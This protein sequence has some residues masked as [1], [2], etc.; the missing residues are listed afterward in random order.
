M[1]AKT[2]ILYRY[3]RELDIDNKSKR[4]DHN[5]RL[6]IVKNIFA[7]NI[8]RLAKPSTFN[9][10]FDSRSF[11]FSYEKLSNDKDH[12]FTQ[13]MNKEME[14]RRGQLSDK[15]LMKLK[16]G[17]Y[18]SLRDD[19]MKK[20]E[21]EIMDTFQIL[22]LSENKDDVLMWSH[23]SSGHKGFCLEFLCN[24]SDFG[25]PLRVR[26]PNDNK[27]PIMD[28]GYRHLDIPKKVFLRKA[29]NWRYE[30]EW[31]MFWDYKS[32]KKE[33][34]TFP[35]SCLTGVIFGFLMPDED[36]KAI[37]DW[38]ELGKS[39]PVLYKAMRSKNEFKMVINKI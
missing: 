35:P 4:E 25:P 21:S 15:E 27:Y 10:P 29:K 39:R 6:E 36:K 32:D 23:Y 17:I 22:C 24:K 34:Q 3:Y 31:R 28:F 16:E 11:I 14:E 20:Y 12:E 1:K 2:R 18:R 33:D 26:Y 5:K 8:I 9:D 13:K 7:N 30:K 19:Y 38:I 37:I